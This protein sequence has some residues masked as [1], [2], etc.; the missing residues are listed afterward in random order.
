VKTHFFIIAFFL[1][2]SPLSWSQDND[3]FWVGHF[4]YLD[5][6]EV[7]DGGSKFYAAS[8]NAIFSYDPLTNELNT[9]TT[10]NG[11]SG[12]LISTLHYSNQYELLLIGYKNGLI[13]VYNEINQEL[14]KVID[15]VAKT[16]IPS[17]QKQINHFNE[18]GEDVYIATDYGISVYNLNN[19][20]FGDTY[21]IG[22]NGS[23]IKINQT[24]IFNNE[25][26]AACGSNEGIKKA[27]LSNPSLINFQFWTTLITGNFT[28]IAAINTQLYTVNSNSRIFEIS[29][30]NF[31][32]LFVY[33]QVVSE[34][35]ISDNGLLVT[36][37]SKVYQYSV[38]FNLTSV[39]T[40]NLEFETNF[41]TALS[42]DGVI[43]IG[44]TDYGVLKSKA[45]SVSEYD[46]IH[47]QGP[48]LNSAFSLKY[49]YNNLWVTFGAYSSNF[50]PY[51]LNKRGI[52]CLRNAEWDNISYDSI[53]QTIESDVYVLN[54]ISIDPLDPN[55]VFVSSFHSGL[56]DVKIDESI[57]LLDQSNSGLESIASNVT[58]RIS[59]TTFDNDANLWVLNSIIQKPLKKLNPTT[60]QWTSY[61][62][63]SIIT[64]PMTD[65]NGFSELVIGPDGTKWI[66]GLKKGLI[67]FN[68]N[69]MNLKNIN[70]NDVANLPSTAVKALALDKNNVLWIGTYK[71]LRVLYNTSSFFTEEIVRTEPIIILEDGLPQELLAQQFIS[72]IIVDGSNNKWISTADAGVFYVSSDGLNTIHHFTKDNSPLP[73]NG[74]NAMALDSENGVVYFGTNRGL[75]SFATGGSRTMET[76][77]DIYVYPNPVRPGFNMA[78][79]KIK[80]KNISEN[81]NIKITDIEGNL[82][83]EAQ[84]NVNLRYKNY[85][86]EIDG[87]TAYWNGKNLANNTVASGVYL[88]LFSDFDTLETKVSKI[89]IIR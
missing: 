21:Y 71:G 56:L 88:V 81:V 85:N 4:S 63:S 77:E 2:F 8:E 23:Q 72:D 54:E 60:N 61:D 50:N 7:V 39:Y 68:E 37:P 64:D 87:G 86:L 80:I 33:P 31:N 14:L 65:E 41:T 13:E 26:F 38:G 22:T 52:S 9:I 51:P 48:L 67:G 28:N 24:A 46:E 42:I 32:P 20:E 29:G 12:E 55:H 78:E 59:G 58:V 1:A 6:K 70:D 75:V 83:A 5:I 17:S 10:V 3:S 49:G 47:P 69:G 45:M 19:L 62:F 25:I 35:K 53:Q 15:I 79:D 44:T 27:S 30:T 74:V 73:S 66:G 43:Y 11:L 89:M 82:V 84:S 40:T 76:L 16:T 36:T 18:N 34:L 57:E